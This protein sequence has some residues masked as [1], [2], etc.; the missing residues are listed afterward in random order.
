MQAQYLMGW[1]HHSGRG[2]PRDFKQAMEWYQ[3]AAAQNMPNAINNIGYMYEHGQ[4]VATDRNEAIKWYK[5]A[6]ALNYKEAKRNLERLG[7]Q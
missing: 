7:Q 2:R 6:A 1:L 4:G 5:R 3:K